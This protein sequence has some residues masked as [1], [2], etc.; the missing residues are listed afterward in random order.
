MDWP[1]RSPDLSPI[2]HVWDALERATATRSSPPRTIEDLKAALLNEWDQLPQA[3]INCLI[4]S[5]TSR[6]EACMA[7]FE[8]YTLMLNSANSVRWT[9][10]AYKQN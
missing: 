5:M 6:C 1:A 9:L 10:L 4:S 8:N 7:Y 3:L 2:Q